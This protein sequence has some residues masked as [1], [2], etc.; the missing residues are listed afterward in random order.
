MM[1]VCET[2]FLLELECQGTL[3]SFSHDIDPIRPHVLKR[4]GKTDVESPTSL[5][6]S[7]DRGIV[8]LL[9]V[10][11]PV[12]TLMLDKSRVI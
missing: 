7:G 11:A 1:S 6:K 8:R 12:K 10:Y 4:L 5:L 9:N 3:N 2:H